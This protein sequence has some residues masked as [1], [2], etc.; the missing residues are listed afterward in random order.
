MKTTFAKYLVENAMPDFLT[1]HKEIMDALYLL[2]PGGHPDKYT[3]NEDGTVDSYGAVSIHNHRM[4]RLPVQFGLVDGSF[5]L[6]HC[7]LISLEGCP[8]SVHGYFSVQDNKITSLKGGPTHV[9]GQYNCSNNALTDLQGAPEIIFGD[10]D[11]SNNSLETMIG[12]PTEVNGSCVVREN[13][14]HSFE[15]FPSKINYKLDVQNNALTTLEGIT[16]YIDEIG[17]SSSPGVIDLNY[18]KIQSG[19]LGL[20]CIKNL[21]TFVVTYH[22]K[23]KVNTD[24]AEDILGKYMLQPDKTFECQQELIVAGFEEIAQL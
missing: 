6:H 5:S 18:N 19:G 10:F 17:I 20:T 23:G 7:G 16:D 2:D 15:G 8:T 22:I 1:D 11:V 13:H 14:L 21:R 12:G 4:K 9:Q 3:I 24:K